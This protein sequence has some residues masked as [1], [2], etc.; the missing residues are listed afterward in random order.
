MNTDK[1]RF[2]YSFIPPLILVLL[3]AVVKVVEV[4]LGLNLGFLGV[5]PLHFEGLPG[6][7]LAPMIHENFNHLIDCFG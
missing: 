3:M 7:L 1:N 6:I 4:L 2:F 5:F